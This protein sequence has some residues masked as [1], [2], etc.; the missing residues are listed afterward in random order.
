MTSSWLPPFLPPHSSA[1]IDGSDCWQLKACCSFLSSMPV[2]T[3]GLSWRWLS[4]SSKACRSVDWHRLATR[5]RGSWA[6]AASPELVECR[7]CS[8]LSAAWQQEWGRARWACW[9]RS[10]D[11]PKCWSRSPYESDSSIGSWNPPT[12]YVACHSHSFWLLSLARYVLDWASWC[13]STYLRAGFWIL[14]EE[15]LDPA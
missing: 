7:A 4:S 6:G 9:C 3:A 8:L 15:S 10:W 5:S 1:A 11:V 2:S 14:V 13:S 12:G